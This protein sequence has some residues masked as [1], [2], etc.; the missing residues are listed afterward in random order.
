MKA[1]PFKFVLFV[2]IAGA[3]MFVVFRPFAYVIAIALLVT[4]GVLGLFYAFRGISML[5]RKFRIRNTIEGIIEDKITDINKQIDILTSDI[6]TIKSELKDIDDQLTAGGLSNFASEKLIRLRDAFDLEEELKEEK[7]SF[8][9]LTV[10]KFNE[11][12][13]DQEVLKQ[14][15]SKR[16]KLKEVR[17]EKPSADVHQSDHLSNDKEII[18]ELDYLT[19]RMDNTVHIDEAKDIQ[20][21]LVNLYR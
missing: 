6:K 12:L 15:S 13:S 4:L 14:I 10:D 11:L 5:V 17:K 18:E 20:K 9:Q 1:N 16:E 8:Y 19:L 2:L 3:L 21:E 7:L